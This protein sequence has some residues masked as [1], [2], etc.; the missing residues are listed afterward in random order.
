[1]HSGTVL[2]IQRFTVHDGPGIRTLVFMKGCPLRCLWCSNPESQRDHAELGFIASRCTG[3]GEC[4]AACP[5]GA[6]TIA[7]GVG[8]AAIDRDMCTACGTCVEACLHD[9]REVAGGRYTI[10]DLLV[11]VQRDNEFYANSGGG[12]TVGGGEPTRQHEF[13]REF[14]RRCK[15]RW[16]HTA[17]QT[18]GHVRWDHLER[19]LEHVDILLYDIK[20]MDPI[21]H[22]QL[23]GV[24]NKVILGNLQRIASGSS[25]PDIVVRIPVVPG[26]NDSTE[27]I[28]ATAAYVSSLENIRGI[29]LLPYHYLARSKY[30]QF[31]MEYRLDYTPVPEPERMARLQE[32]IASFGLAVSR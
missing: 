25:R 30:A 3:C 17:L 31:G 2:N 19:I 8:V 9:A 22:K 28:T 11:E 20:H 26:L 29:E 14:L 15:D 24:S 21:A 27:N 32:I 13:V 4:V 16:L 6:A 23:T 10:D 18:C 5:N 12:V 7:P 1:M